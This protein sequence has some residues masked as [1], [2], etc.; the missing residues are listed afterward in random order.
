MNL[1]EWTGSNCREDSATSCQAADGMSASVMRELAGRYITAPS[2]LGKISRFATTIRKCVFK[3][4][5]VRSN[6]VLEREKEREKE[7]GRD[8]ESGINF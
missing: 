3:H 6:G 5:S 8:R 2:A 7:R 4:P 1:G